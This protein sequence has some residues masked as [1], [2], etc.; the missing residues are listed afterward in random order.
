MPRVLL[1][2]AMACVLCACGGGQPSTEYFPLDP[3]LSWEYRVHERSPAVD[4]EQRLGQ[5]NLRPVTREGQRYARRLSSDGNEYWLQRGE[6]ALQRVGLRRAIDFEPRMDEEPRTVLQLPPVVG[7]WWE[8]ESRPYILERVEPFRERFA[9][10]ESK[11]IGL[12]MKVAALDDVVEV[13]AGTFERCLRLEGS[14]SLHVL[15]DARIGASEVP[16]THIEWYAPG[17]GL[18]KLVRTE[19]LDTPA[20]VGGQITMEL[21]KFER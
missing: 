19:S 1:L 17:V 13:P 3:G 15:A 11:R 7:Q 20:I 21:V 8:V 9:Q 12:Q 18:V 5:R 10:D 2:V 6:N 4:R 14:G 16:V